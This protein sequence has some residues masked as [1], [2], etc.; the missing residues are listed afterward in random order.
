MKKVRRRINLVFISILSL[1]ILT[2]CNYKGYRGEHKALYT[3]AVNSIMAVNGYYDSPSLADSEI[4]I[5]ETDSYGKVLYSY[6]ESGWYAL[7][8]AQA[9]DEEYVYY[10][11][12]FNFIVAERERWN[13]VSDAHFTNDEIADLKKLNDFNKEFDETKC[14]K[15]E[16]VTLKKSPKLPKDVE[17]ELK[18]LCEDF[19]RTSGCKGES[20]VYRYVEFCTYDNYGRMLFYVFGIHSD[21]YG[22]GVSP[23]SKNRYFDMAIIFNPD[24]SFDEE[25][26]ILEL[27]DLFHYQKELKKF[28]EY[29]QWNQP[30]KI[31]D[32]GN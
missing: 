2:G 23:D 20:S 14:I 10:Y 18:V 30:F 12:D 13:S 8:I 26:A 11:E 22:Q 29:H 27:T 7:C 1:L 19:A 17:K 31:I 4:E 5:I 24:W 6:H 32:V 3:E 15:K 28:K 25:N 9:Y 21:M 16:I